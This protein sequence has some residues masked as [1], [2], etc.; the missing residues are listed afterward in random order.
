MNTLIDEHV[1]YVVSRLPKC[2]FDI[3]KQHKVFLAGGFIRSLISDEKP[4]DIDL[5]CQSS[6]VINRVESEINEYDD[7]KRLKTKNAITLFNGLKSPIQLITRWYYDDPI[8][9]IDEFD[10][11]I[12]KCVI[13]FE[14]FVDN[15]NGIWKSLCS[16][17][18]YCDLASKTLRYTEPDRLED[19][20]G[21]I[22]RV[23]KFLRRGYKISPE[24]FTKVVMRWLSGVNN[25]ENI[26]HDNE[27]LTKVLCGLLREVDPMNIDIL[28]NDIINNDEGDE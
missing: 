27:H 9:L 16:D 11:T 1:K 2:V 10:F 7:F 24:E 12:A 3:M 28:T 22:L 17:M 25:L 14:R 5:L 13:W 4:S 15:K 23:L 18:F 8:K 21:S 26:C 19:A 20:G 6:D